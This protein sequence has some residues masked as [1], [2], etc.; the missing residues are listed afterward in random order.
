MV[1]AVFVQKR[2]TA[3]SKEHARTVHYKLLRRIGVSAG[4]KPL[5]EYDPSAADP[6]N[7][8]GATEAFRL[9]S[10]RCDDEVGEACEWL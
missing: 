7:D 5:V 10:Y 8:G 4:E 1:E 2:G 9:L 3:G 6:S